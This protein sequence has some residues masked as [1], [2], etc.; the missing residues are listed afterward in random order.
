MHTYDIVGAIAIVKKTS[1]NLKT[2]GEGSKGQVKECSD[3]YEPLWASA[4][5]LRSLA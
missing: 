5:F 2:D 3:L 4:P 1:R